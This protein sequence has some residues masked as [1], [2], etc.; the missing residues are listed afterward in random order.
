MGSGDLDLVDFSKILK[1]TFDHISKTICDMNMIF[2]GM[3]H[4]S[5]Y[6]EIV[7]AF[8]YIFYVF[9]LFGG[10]EDKKMA[11]NPYF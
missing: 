7:K 4:L 3:I 11:Q 2:P 9:A 10:L 8:F 6:S 5:V 1:F